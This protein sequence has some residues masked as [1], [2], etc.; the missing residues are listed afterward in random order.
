MS[1]TLRAELARL[2]AIGVAA[3]QGEAVLSEHT[4][5][6][7]HALEFKRGERSLQ[8]SWPEP[9][10]GGRLRVIGIGKAVE[11]MAHG[12]R[13]SLRAA[14]RDVDDGLLVVRDH[15]SQHEKLVP[16]RVVIGDHPLPGP[17]SERAARE[18]LEFIG[19]PTAADRFVVLLSGGASALCALPVPGVTLE[20]KRRITAALMQRG[21]PIAELNRVRRSLSAIKGGKLA[22]RLAPAAFV[23]LAIS[24]V[25]GDDPAVIGSAPTWQDDLSAAQRSPY[26]VIATLD[27]TLQAI[28]GAA[29][30]RG[31]HIESMGRC[32]Y[33]QVAEESEKILQ[34]IDVLIRRGNPRGGVHLLLAGGEPLVEVRGQGRGGR[35]QEFA[36]RLA[37][38]LAKRAAVDP[39]YADVLGLVAGTDGSD[40]PTPAAGGFFDGRT[41]ARLEMQGLR[42]TDLLDA[43]DSYHALQASGD[44]FVTGP[45]GT[46]IADV[47]MVAI[48]SG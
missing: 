5:A 44:L 39:R 19:S 41:V 13:A 12:L 14:G 37:A 33:A 16:W 32:I 47:L 1:S 22:A 43:N 15:D 18:L 34:R 6:L 11:G 40:G 8:L 21:A 26:I 28:E 46:N 42:V 7:A 23:T 35:A 27:D 4:H 9:K 3:V 48:P 31:W 38:G 20:E 29:M 10:Q 36:L 25:P 30:N 2:H 17:A 45:T 24:D